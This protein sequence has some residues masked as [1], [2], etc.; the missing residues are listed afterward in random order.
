MNWDSLWI[1]GHAATM[2]PAGVVRDAA[3]AVAG[4]R[5]AWI[6][7]RA[8]LPAGTAAE[9]HDL[10]GRWLT[11]GLIDAHT[12]LVFGGNRAAEFEM[13]LEGASY[14]EIARA[15]GGIVSTVTA[16]RAADAETLADLAA[17]RLERLLAEGVT[18]VEV[19]SGLKTSTIS[20]SSRLEKAVRPMLASLCS[21]RAPTSKP[22]ERSGRSSGL[23]TKEPGKKP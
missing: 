23:P 13:R 11:P 4:G 14:E 17:P 19:K 1:N 20:S 2:G 3:V 7:P 15:G 5:I 16:T 18:V 10:G 21:H 9:E 22:R 6:G 8:D 12:H